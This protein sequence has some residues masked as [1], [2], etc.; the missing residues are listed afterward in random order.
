MMYSLPGSG[1]WWEEEWERAKLSSDAPIFVPLA[2]AAS[3]MLLLAP[4][5]PAENEVRTALNSTALPFDANVDSIVDGV[6]T[7]LNARAAPFCLPMDQQRT[8]LSASAS[9]F[10]PHG[11]KRRT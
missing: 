11:S 5:R 8:A 2:H 1:G 9:A 4:A 7:G 6:R 3:D 10:Q